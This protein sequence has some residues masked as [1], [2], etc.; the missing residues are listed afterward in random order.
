MQLRAVCRLR[1]TRASKT[2]PV[3]KPQGFVFVRPLRGRVRRDP[4]H[5]GCSVRPF[6][7]NPAPIHRP[8]NE[9]AASQP[10]QGARTASR[11]PAAAP[12]GSA[13]L[14]PL[15]QSQLGDHLP[16]TIRQPIA[17][18]CPGLSAAFAAP[19]SNPPA[20]PG[21]PTDICH[22]PAQPR[23]PGTPPPSQY[24]DKKIPRKQQRLRRYCGNHSY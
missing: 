16:S 1:A 2:A 23:P 9:R 7:P 17:P 12:A 3:P 15:P 5:I 20:R 4:H 10:S 6:R 11:R 19:P 13:P 21:R 22:R 8:V 14:H 18:R 24:R